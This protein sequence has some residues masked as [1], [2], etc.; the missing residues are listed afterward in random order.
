MY[1][2]GYDGGMGSVGA[3]LGAFFWIIL[4]ALYLYFAFTQYKIA[5]KCGCHDSAWWAWVPIM[6]TFLLIK[7]AQKEW[8]WFVLCLVPIVNIVVFAMLWIQVAKLAGHAPIWGVLVLLPVINF[9]AIG[10]MAFTGEHPGAIPPS[11][12][13]PKRETQPVG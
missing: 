7:M 4:V 1:E 6:N 3:G 5:H 10:V 11:D 13:K 2:A 12:H 8:W 9:V